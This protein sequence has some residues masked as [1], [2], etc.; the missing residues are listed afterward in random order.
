MTGT[1]TADPYLRR[2][3]GGNVALIR[4]GAAI[5][6]NSAGNRGFCGKK[7]TTGVPQRGTS[8]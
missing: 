8:I 5:A 2:P 3:D 1:L 7:D 4:R 6:Q